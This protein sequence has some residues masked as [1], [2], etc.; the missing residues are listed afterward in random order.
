[1]HGINAWDTNK[2]G[3]IIIDC[4][5][6]VASLKVQTFNVHLEDVFEAEHDDAINTGIMLG[7]YD[8]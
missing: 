5:C 4:I 1:M 3:N 6:G 8:A 7:H 2:D